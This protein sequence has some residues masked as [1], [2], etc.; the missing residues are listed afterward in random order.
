MVP[1]S[2]R[3]NKDMRNS[4]EA[5]AL[6]A[7]RPRN[8]YREDSM[9]YILFCWLLYKHFGYG[10]VSLFCEGISLEERTVLRCWSGSEVKDVRVKFHAWKE[11]Q[12]NPLTRFLSTRRSQKRNKTIANVF[13]LV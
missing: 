3:M 11:Q 1:D 2:I 8:R 5:N 12:Y 6:K 10:F 7:Y 13:F 4:R 9:S